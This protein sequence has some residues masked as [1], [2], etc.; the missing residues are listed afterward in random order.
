MN[1]ILVF[2]NTGDEIPFESVN[3]EVLEFY[4]EQ[5]NKQNLNKFSPKNQLL[6]KI[7]LSQVNTL[8][9]TVEKVNQWLYDLADIKFDLH[10]SESY[11]DQ[12]ILNKLHA[13]WAIA[14]TLPYDIQKKRKQFN[15]SGIAEQIHDM[16]PDDIQTPP[17]GVVLEKI[18]YSKIYYSLNSLHIH[19]LEETFND[20]GFQVSNIWTNVADNPFSKTILTNDIANLRISFNHLGRTLY[21]KFE[22]FDMNL[23]YNDENSYNELL[24]FVSLNLQPAQTI[25]MSKE[26]TN[27][28]KRHNRE[29][30]GEFLN[31]GNIP[32]LYENLTKY[33][34]IIFKNLLDNNTFSIHKTQG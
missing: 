31:I 20:I 22:N 27:W 12:N 2:D 24:G 29:P 7:I 34:K 18:D 33:R 15:F 17:L 4:I 9:L 1:Y 14:Q 25:P 5:L 10:D 28:C 26:Y 32:N 11:L 30:V 3:Q 23:E 6:G 13:D 16:F 19:R 8:K 21:N